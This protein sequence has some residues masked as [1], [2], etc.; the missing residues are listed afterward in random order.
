[1]VNLL[2][3]DAFAQAQGASVQQPAFWQ[4]LMPIVIIFIIFYFLMIRPQKKKMDQEQAFLAGLNKGDEVYTKSGMIGTISGLTDRVVTLEVADGVR[5]KVLRGQIAGL[6][7]T[8]LEE[9]NKNK[10]K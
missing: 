7:N 1:M 3:S 9:Q 8:L 10:K 6:M 4:S 2:W 5:V